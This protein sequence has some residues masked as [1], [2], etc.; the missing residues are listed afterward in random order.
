MNRFGDDRIDIVSVR[1]RTT[2]MWRKKVLWMD[3]QT[4][5]GKKKQSLNVCDTT[6][7]THK[8]QVQSGI[9]TCAKKM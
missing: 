3:R 4:D 9:P 8:K 6:Q 1:E 5:I 2:L 7:A